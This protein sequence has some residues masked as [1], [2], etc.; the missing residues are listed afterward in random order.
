MAPI[1]QSH[2]EPAESTSAEDRIHVRSPISP[3]LA[4]RGYRGVSTPIDSLTV[5]GRPSTTARR[6][7][8]SS[9]TNS[10]ALLMAGTSGQF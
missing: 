2:I 3:S 4:R 6:T 10:N 5:S 7:D 1:V 9:R 8:A